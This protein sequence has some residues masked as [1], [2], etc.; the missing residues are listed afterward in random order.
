[1]RSKESWLVLFALAAGD[2]FG[3]VA[4]VAFVVA[5]AATISGVLVVLA[6]GGGGGGGVV[7]ALVADC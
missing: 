2:R 7:V 5:A 3:D 4:S 1:M 6:V